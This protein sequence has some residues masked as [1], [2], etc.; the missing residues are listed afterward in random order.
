MVRSGARTSGSLILKL[1]EQRPLTVFGNGFDVSDF[2]ISRD[3]REV[4]LERPEE[5]S[6]IVLLDLHH[7]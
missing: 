6:D 3:G 4:V 7:R 1:E 5:E 2:D